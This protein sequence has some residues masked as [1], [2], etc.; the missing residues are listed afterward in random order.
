MAFLRFATFGRVIQCAALAFCLA[1]SRDASAQVL[2]PGSAFGGG[3]RVVSPPDLFVVNAPAVSASALPRVFDGTPVPAPSTGEALPKVFAPT[4]PRTS[5]TRYPWRR[6][7]VATVFWIGE[8]PSHRNPT[9]NN[10]SSWD[11]AWESNFGGYDDPD[12][13]N[14]QDYR[15][16]KFIPRQN[17]FYIALPYNDIE[18]G[19]YKTKKSAKEAVPWFKKRFEQEGHTVLKGQWLAIRRGSKVC[20]AQWEDCGPFE[21]DDWEY[22]FG[23]K[24]PNNPK[25]DGAGLDVSPAIKTYLG[26]ATKAVCDWRFVDEEEVPEGPWRDYGD[27]NPFARAKSVTPDNSAPVERI[28]KLRELRDEYL[29]NMPLAR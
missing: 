2:T 17:P 25:N 22:V 21:T 6:N 1:G 20:Y 18:S 14:R 19:T 15:P 28:V 8:K 29:R 4:Q 24:R 5:Y 9:P 11:R 12:E 23:D 7:I 10:K 3:P 16:K 26:F 27:N 13:S